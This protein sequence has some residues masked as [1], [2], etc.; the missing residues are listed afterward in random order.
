MLHMGNRAVVD[1]PHGKRP[2]R[3]PARPVRRH[4]RLDPSRR[5]T[6]HISSRRARR[7]GH[8]ILGSVTRAAYRPPP[9]MAELGEQVPKWGPVVLRG[10]P[11]IERIKKADAHRPAPMTRP[12]ATRRRE[13]A[14]DPTIL[15]TLILCS[16]NLIFISPCPRIRDDALRT[17]GHRPP[18]PTQDSCQTS[19]MI[20][21]KWLTP[22]GRAPRQEL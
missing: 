8:R 5:R 10:S 16:V 2:K 19:L 20:N 9:G 6:I 21:I 1:D 11:Y 15:L 13:R 18:L 7:L 4:G 22:P 17:P 3:R 12:V 14:V